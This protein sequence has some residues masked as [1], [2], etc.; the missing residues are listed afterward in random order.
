MNHV[1]AFEREILRKLPT[2]GCINTV[3]W[4]LRLFIVI[5]AVYIIQ[6]QVDYDISVA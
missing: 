6:A 2:L 5:G 4:L 3:R 1:L